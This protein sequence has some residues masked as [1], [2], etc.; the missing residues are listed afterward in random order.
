[1]A[2]SGLAGCTSLFE[3]D[4]WLSGLDQGK[5]EV[6]AASASPWVE[7]RK[8]NASLRARV[9]HPDNEL[10]GYDLLFESGLGKLRIKYRINGKRFFVHIQSPEGESWKATISAKQGFRAIVQSGIALE[11]PHIS[12]LKDKYKIIQLYEKLLSH[13]G[14]EKLQTLDEIIEIGDKPFILPKY[15]INHNLLLTD[16]V[17]YKIER[18]IKQTKSF[19][20]IAAMAELYECLDDQVAEDLSQALSANLTHSQALDPGDGGGSTGGVSTGCMAG[21]GLA[22]VG[23]ISSIAGLFFCATV[24]GCIWA[25]IGFKVAEGSTLLCIAC[26]IEGARA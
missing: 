16:P 7:I 5:G 9:V 4:Y 11:S 12:D 25:G 13:I 14:E 17:W 22:A 2:L 15:N 10:L 20:L 19:T 3:A 21:C 6:T 24:A 23:L 26:V 18:Q 1:M 8:G